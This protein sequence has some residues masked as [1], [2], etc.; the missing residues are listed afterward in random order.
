LLRPRPSFYY[1][2][3]VAGSDISC[4][5]GVRRSSERTT[6][7][8]ASLARNESTLASNK[9]LLADLGGMGMADSTLR[10]YLEAL[11]RIYLIDDVPAWNPALRSPV[12]IRASAKHH[13]ADPSLAAAALGASPDSLLSDLKTLGLLFESLV[14]HDLKVYALA[15]EAKVSHY[16]DNVDLEADAIVHTPDGRWGAVEI[17]LGA[18]QEDDAAKSLNALERKLVSRGER[19][20]AFKAV[21]VGTGAFG[22]VRKDGVQVIPVDRLGA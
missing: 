9:A 2:E 19:Q 8:L 21:V 22:H 3:V 20:P 7:I 13:L 15:S 4:V 6:A 16:H 10:D 12:R 17:K 5:D 14:L 18:N 11:K 1:L